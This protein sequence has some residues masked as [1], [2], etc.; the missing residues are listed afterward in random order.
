MRLNDAQRSTLAARVGATQWQLVTNRGGA[1]NA[2]QAAPVA[3]S[4]FVT[5]QPILM[6]ANLGGDK[7]EKGMDDGLWQELANLHREAVKLD[8]ASVALMRTEFPTAAQ[9]GRIAMGGKGRM[10]DPILRV[11]RRFE[12]SIALDTVRNEYLLH[13]RIHEKFAAGEALTANVDQLNEWVY[14]ELFLTPSSDPWL[15]LAPPDVYTALDNNGQ[16]TADIK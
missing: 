13:R 16:L 9:A 11:V 12:E 5:E 8:V 14:A 6:F 3:V 4:K 7:L 1:P 2:R 10:E 15:G